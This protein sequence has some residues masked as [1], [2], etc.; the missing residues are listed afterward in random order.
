MQDHYELCQQVSLPCSVQMGSPIG[1]TTK[2]S[3]KEKR[4]RGEWGQFIPLGWSLQ[5]RGRL[6]VSP[7][8]MLIIR[9]PSIHS[10][11]SPKFQASLPP[12]ILSR[13][14]GNSM[15]LLLSRRHYVYVVILLHSAHILLL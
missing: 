15:S 12:L 10:P 1:S 3:E 5:D 6:A 13:T 9:S 11:L 2:R 8:V 7:R 14:L 4:V